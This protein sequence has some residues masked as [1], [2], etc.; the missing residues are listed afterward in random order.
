MVI[1]TKLGGSEM[2]LDLISNLLDIG[3]TNVTSN[4]NKPQHT[5]RQRWDITKIVIDTSTKEINEA[6]LAQLGQAIDEYFEP[7]AVTTELKMLSNDI[8]QLSP[9]KQPQAYPVTA[10]WLKRPAVIGEKDQK[11]NKK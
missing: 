2:S 5:G 3:E 6:S 10:V 7:F 11:E 1:N 9:Q 8:V 4:M